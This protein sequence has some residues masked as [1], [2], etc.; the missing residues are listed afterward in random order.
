MNKMM[1]KPVAM[2]AL[3]LATSTAFSQVQLVK[4]PVLAPQGK[5]LIKPIGPIDPAALRSPAAI[6]SNS[7]DRMEA[8]RR[9][10]SQNV[11]VDAALTALRKAF[12][13]WIQAESTSLSAAGYPAAQLVVAMKQVYD[14]QPDEMLARMPAMGVDESSLAKQ[15]TSLY[16]LDFDPLLATLRRGYAHGT[17]TEFGYALGA[18]DYTVEQMVQ[19]GHRYFVGRF[20]DPTSAGAPFP[21]A[22]RMY[23]LLM[24]ENPLREQVQINHYALFQLLMAGGY[25]PQQV[26]AEVPM[27]QYS[28]VSNLPMDEVSTCVQQNSADGGPARGRNVDQINPQL[29]IRMAA[30]GTASHPGGRRSCIVKFLGLLR[31]NGT[32]RDVASVLADLSVSC[33]P[34]TNMACP[35]QR[36]AVVGSMLNEA[37]F[38]S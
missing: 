16:A 10:K 2:L 31:A 25:S 23:G 21:N 27:G 5:P 32:R 14:L 1:T 7:P 29:V 22:K 9:L 34:L 28:P 17:R 11:P 26:I 37:G 13:S 20:P 30:D 35:A 8:A 24:L 33:V 12:G 6:A 18:M 19:T 3:L 38:G 4:K 36:A 15:L